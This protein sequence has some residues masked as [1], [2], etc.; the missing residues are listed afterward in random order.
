[1]NSAAAI[2]P[3]VAA[4]TS[5][6][7]HAGRNV[8]KKR[9]VPMRKNSDAA[10]ANEIANAK[11]TMPV[12]L[13]IRIFLRRAFRAASCLSA[14]SLMTHFNSSRKDLIISLSAV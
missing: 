10:P 1:M 11:I 8:S 3:A 6:A 2:T 7:C 14:Y 5:Q 13:I 4:M 9:S 12:M